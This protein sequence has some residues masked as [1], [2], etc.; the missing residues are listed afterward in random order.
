[1][2]FPISKHRLQTTFDNSKR[3]ILN[4]IRVVYNKHC[5]ERVSSQQQRDDSPVRVVKATFFRSFGN[6][7][8]RHALGSKATFIYC[9]QACK[10]K[11]STLYTLRPPW[12]VRQG[13]NCLP[14][15]FITQS[16]TLINGGRVDGSEVLKQTQRH[17]LRNRV[18][19]YSV[20]YPSALTSASAW[21]SGGLSAVCHP[22]EQPN[23]SQLRYPPRPVHS[24]AYFR[25]SKRGT[26]SFQQLCLGVQLNITNTAKYFLRSSLLCKFPK[27]PH[28]PSHSLNEASYVYSANVKHAH[29]YQPPTPHSTSGKSVL[30]YAAANTAA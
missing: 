8:P 27:K 15:P 23:N 9:M 18:R 11:R 5:A 22:H 30:A 19:I 3:P 6:V 10:V 28:H 24:P 7:F 17:R 16:A 2:A 25:S 12:L 1:M 14:S 13:H 21:A 29:A 20:D 4:S 26:A